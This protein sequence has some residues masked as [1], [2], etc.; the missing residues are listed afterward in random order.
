MKKAI[1]TFLSAFIAIAGWAQ[2]ISKAEPTA[3]DYINLL[4]K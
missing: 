4:N 3:K 1:I 2:E